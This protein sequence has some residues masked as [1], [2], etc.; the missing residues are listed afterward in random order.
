MLCRIWNEVA[1]RWDMHCITHGSHIEHLWINAC[2]L[3][4]CY[5]AIHFPICNLNKKLQA[6]YTVLQ[7]MVILYSSSYF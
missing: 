1:F 7:F 5:G 2:L 3:G 6:F 4:H